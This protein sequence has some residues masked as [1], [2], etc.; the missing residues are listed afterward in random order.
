M[1]AA[2]P[3]VDNFISGHSARAVQELLDAIR[4]A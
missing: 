1:A 2:L 3:Y 4:E